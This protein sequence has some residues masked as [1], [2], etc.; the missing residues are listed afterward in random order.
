MGQL[1]FGGSSSDG[2]GGVKAT[3]LTVDREGEP[4]W[5]YRY[6]ESDTLLGFINDLSPT[7]DGG[8]L[9]AG[10][11]EATSGTEDFWLL[12]TSLE[13]LL[14]DCNC[15]DDATLQRDTLFTTPGG[16]GMDMGPANCSP[17]GINHNCMPIDSVRQEFCDQ[18]L[19]ESC[20]LDF[21]F[22]QVDSCGQVA[23]S[24]SDTTLVGLTWDFGDAMTRRPL[25]SRLRF[26]N[27]PEVVLILSAFQL[28]IWSV[29]KRFV[30]R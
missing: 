27:S 2:A 26:I 24:A 30:K 8:F 14:K 9:M 19:P 12:K 10:N 13:G 1:R 5:S 23:F 28:M 7:V 20:M 29:W 15:F 17:I 18:T 3:V 6:N 16:I 22:E 4:V 25:E 21:V 11:H